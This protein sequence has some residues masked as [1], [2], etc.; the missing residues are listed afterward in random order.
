MISMNIIYLDTLFLVNFLCDYLLFLCTARVGGAEIRRIPI[1]LASVSGGIYACLCNLPTFAW[2]AHPLIKLCCCI[3][4]CLIAFGKEPNRLRCILMFVCISAL[5][6][7]LITA[8]SLSYEGLEYLPLSFKSIVLIF[9]IVYFLLSFFFRNTPHIHSKQY[10]IV[11][12]QLNGKTVSFRALRDSGNELY[13]PITNRPVL[14]CHPNT[15]RPLF[16]P[17]ITWTD[18]PYEQFT[19]MSSLEATHGRMRLIPCRTVTG[20]GM[21]LGFQADSVIINGKAEQHIVAFSQSKFTADSPYQ[22]I[23]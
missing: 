16:A 10:H 13:D 2:L 7:G 4:L 14:I 23:Y 15:L 21:L 8:A 6:G 22:G 5:A 20:S 3:S 18:D 19:Y 1:L 12:V 9:S 17:S 11:T